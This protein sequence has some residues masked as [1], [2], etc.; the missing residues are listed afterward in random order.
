MLLLLFL[1]F[2]VWN[3]TKIFTWA[4]LGYDFLRMYEEKKS[5]HPPIV[6]E[7]NVSSSTKPN[8]YENYLF[9]ISGGVINLIGKNIIIWKA[10]AVQPSPII[11]QF[12]MSIFFFFF[13]AFFLMF[14]SFWYF[15]F[16]SLLMFRLLNYDKI[17]IK[18]NDRKIYIIE[19]CRVEWSSRK[20][21]KS[22]KMKNYLPAFK[23]SFYFYFVLFEIIDR[24]ISKLIIITYFF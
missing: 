9:A 12:F 1:D 17:H 20:I 16:F 22:E 10:L 5:C 6:W 13:F 8:N 18:K 3:I 19:K 14:V 7:L 24:L 23:Y 21:C 11:F 15:F 2:Y 4:R